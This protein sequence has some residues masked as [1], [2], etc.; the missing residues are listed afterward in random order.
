[1]VEVDQY[2]H[3]GLYRYSIE[4]TEY[5]ELTDEQYAAVMCDLARRE[6][7]PLQ[8]T[9]R[10]KLIQAHLGM[11][12]SMAVNTSFH[13]YGLSMEDFVGIGN[14]ALVKRFACFK[15]NKNARF[16]T[17]MR[18]V[19]ER[20]IY[21]NLKK[22]IIWDQADDVDL[23]L[24]GNDFSGRRCCEF[25]RK[26]E[27]AIHTLSDEEQTIVRMLFYAAE[28]PD[29]KAVAK[30]LHRTE[31]GLKLSLQKICDKLRPQLR[32]VYRV[33]HSSIFVF[34]TAFLARI[35]LIQRK[36]I[37]AI[38]LVRLLQSKGKRIYYLNTD[39]KPRYCPKYSL[40]E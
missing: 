21:G 13:Y 34:Q 20:W 19:V 26:V 33:R 32:G 11:V 8:E 39:V 18:K 3:P 9:A 40:V 10:V 35:P 29:I 4:L 38:L 6:E 12:L 2:R 36:V 37:K 7:D 23:E 31:N 28:R 15:L 25:V 22:H 27:D 14:H 5:P 1:M 30:T 16:S 24:I 17:Y